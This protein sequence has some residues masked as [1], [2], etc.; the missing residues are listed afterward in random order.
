MLKN[1]QAKN[2]TS[3]MLYLNTLANVFWHMIYKDLFFNCLKNI[4]TYK[5]H[6]FQAL[7][8]QKSQ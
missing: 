1:S 4:L 2:H 5:F 3:I 8:F 6:K 7:D